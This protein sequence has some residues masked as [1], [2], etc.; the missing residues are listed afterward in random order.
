MAISAPLMKL[1]SSEARNSTRSAH[2][3]GVPWRCS[4]IDTRAAWTK[5]SPPEREK[6]VS[7]I[8]A[9]WIEL[10]RMFHCEN[11][12]TAV[13]AHKQDLAALSGQS[14]GQALTG[15]GVDVGQDHRGF[16][17]HEELRLCCPLPSRGAGDQRNL[18]RQPCHF[19]TSDAS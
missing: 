15:R 17:P 9:G 6:L 3:F 12:R 2:S 10:T 5:A 16:F 14:L 4:G 13:L 19:L 18:A 8:N 11:C 7:A 1:D